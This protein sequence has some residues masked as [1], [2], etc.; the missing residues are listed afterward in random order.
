MHSL[1]V[2]SNRVGLRFAINKLRLRSHSSLNHQI[3]SGVRIQTLREKEMMDSMMFTLETDMLRQRQQVQQ[4]YL[5]KGSFPRE[6]LRER[7][8]SAQTSANLNQECLTHTI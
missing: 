8:E 2:P 3:S 5:E 7:T 4:K 1:C 6:R